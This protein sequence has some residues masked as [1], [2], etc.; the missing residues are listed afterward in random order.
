[1]VVM[2]LLGQSHLFLEAKHLGAVFA[3]AAVH[4]VVA[5]EDLAYA[6]GESGYDARMVVQ[7]GGFDELDVRVGGG[8]LV[9]E[10]VDAVDENSGEQESRERR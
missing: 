10:A 3:H 9:G 2:A 4:V 7:V 5:V 8:N 1:M 6:V